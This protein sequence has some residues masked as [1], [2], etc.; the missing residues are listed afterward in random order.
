MLF[1]YMQKSIIN[2]PNI[3]S[4]AFFCTVIKRSGEI[5]FNR[6][7]SFVYAHQPYSVLF[8]CHSQLK[9]SISELSNIRCAVEKL[10]FPIYFPTYPIS[11]RELEMLW[12]FC[13]SCECVYIPLERYE[14]LQIRVFIEYIFHALMRFFFP[15]SPISSRYDEG[16][17]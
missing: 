11:V 17:K 2:F 15:F 8:G 6:I 7:V 3:L 12:W 9:F 13:R 16:M 5:H 10:N 4:Q 1:K 14:S